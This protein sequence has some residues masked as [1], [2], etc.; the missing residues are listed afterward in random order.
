MYNNIE[1]DESGFASQYPRRA[2]NWSRAGPKKM[3]VQH[4]GNSPKIAKT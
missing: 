3:T 2:E 1:K 4:H